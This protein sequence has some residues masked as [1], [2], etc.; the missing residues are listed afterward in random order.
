MER[1]RGENQYWIRNH[2]SRRWKE[3]GWSGRL[4]RS[5]HDQELIV[6]VAIRLRRI[7]KST[8]TS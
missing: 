1:S 7:R 8:R 6:R 3:E 2:V 5:F 4:I